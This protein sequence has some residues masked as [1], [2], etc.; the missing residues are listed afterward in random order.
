MGEVAG[1]SAGGVGGERCWPSL[2]VCLWRL[3]LCVGMF[4]PAFGSVYADAGIAR[5]LSCARVSSLAE[6]LLGPAAEGGDVEQD[7]F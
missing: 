6:S 2:Y 1:H 5:S 3:A 7:G 4:I